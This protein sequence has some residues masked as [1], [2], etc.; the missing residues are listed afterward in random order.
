MINET[1][2]SK[3]DNTYIADDDKDSDAG[4]EYK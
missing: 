3:N 2:E 4:L 1:E